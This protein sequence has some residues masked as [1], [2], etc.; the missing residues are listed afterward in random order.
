MR[1]NK[2]IFFLLLLGFSF[3]TCQNSDRQNIGKS[4]LN[5]DPLP[6]WN[7]GPRKEKILKF[8]AVVS[9]SA[10]T[11]FV[12]EDNRI[13]VFDND[14]TLWSERPV[15]FQ[16][17]F[18]LD[19]IKTLAPDHPEWKDQQPFKAVLENDMKT[20]LASGEHG[21]LKLIMASHSGMTTT[22]FEGIVKDWIAVA[23]HPDTGKHFTEMVYQPMLEL[24]SFLQE[25][26]FKT[27]IVSGGGIEF[28]RPWVEEV[29]GIPPEQVIGSSIKTEFQINNGIPQLIR[30]PELD[31][32]DDKEGKP[33]AI[34]KFIGKKPIAAFGN[35]DGDLQMLQWTDSHKENSLMVYIHHTD[36][37]REWAYDRDSHV[38]RLDKGLDEAAKKNWLVVDMNN[39][40]K[41][42]YPNN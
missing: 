14:G 28:M 2:A 32:L 25:N 22:E 1:S 39:D 42:I 6:S 4:V 18:A 17:Y 29:Y 13:V 30:L 27:Y 7:D 38:G 23:R 35:S 26:N 16:L 36:S 9:D 40:W 12:H 8:I 10:N 21:L 41:S 37:V 5:V 24:L 19:R 34:N 31:F 33:I 15:Y 3:Y 11:S 20:L